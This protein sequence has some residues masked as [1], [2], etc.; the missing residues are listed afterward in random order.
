MKIIGVILIPTHGIG[1]NIFFTFMVMF[2]TIIY[3]L[4]VIGV[5]NV[6]FCFFKAKL[7]DMIVSIYL[8]WLT[9]S[10]ILFSPCLLVLSKDVNQMV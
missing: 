8:L 4:T 10:N 1:H 5:Q 6:I 7:M 2:M 3:I 9:L